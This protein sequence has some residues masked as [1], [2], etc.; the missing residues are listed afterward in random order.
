VKIGRWG[1][2]ALAP[3]LT[4][5]AVGAWRRHER[6]DMGPLAA[7]PAARVLS[8]RVGEGVDFSADAPGARA[9]AW[10]VW[11][12][13]VSRDRTW[14]YRPGPDDAGWQ[15][16]SVAVVG[17]GSRAE[18]TWDVGVV[19]AV[20]PALLEATPPPGPVT[21]RAGDPTGFR[22]DA[23][24]PAA[25]PTDRLRFEW[26]V[27]GEAVQRDEQPAAAASSS[28]ALGETEPGPHRL[29]VRVGED[30][31]AALRVEWT[32]EVEPGAPAELPGPPEPRLVRMPGSRR[33]TALA[34]QALR[35][36]AGVTPALPRTRFV[37]AVD[38][39]PVQRGA[40]ARFDY[41]PDDPGL[42]RVSVT[43]SASDALIG[44]DSWKIEVSEPNGPP[45]PTVAAAPAADGPPRTP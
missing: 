27:D 24:L 31:H 18:R 30:E 22:C 20:E 1:V 38:G 26:A 25:R 40:D 5:A 13:E 23:R 36:A 16:V 17:P 33:L 14:S 10:S 41:T 43:A 19:P 4:L 3:V 34:G 35:F 44:T 12:R 15:Q 8:V 29:S 45:S 7:G 42:H 9:F 6:T 37:W 32:V 2:A 11:G 39:E 28:F 21:V